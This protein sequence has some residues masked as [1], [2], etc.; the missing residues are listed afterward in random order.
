MCYQAK[1]GDKFVEGK[2]RPVYTSHKPEYVSQ[3]PQVLIN[4]GKKSFNYLE[5]YCGFDIETTNVV[6]SD[7]K[8]GY[9]YHGQMSFFTETE[10]ILYTVRTWEQFKYLIDKL[11]SHFH[12]SEKNRL[13]IW[14]ANM[15][16]E[17]QFM[18]KWFEW[19]QGQF[20]FFAKEKHHP[21]LATYKGVEF[22]EALSISGSSLAQLCKDFTY[23]QKLV[24]KYDYNK[25]RNNQYQLTKEELDYCMNDVIPLAEWSKFI[26]DKYI[27]VENKVPLTKTGLTRA[28]VKAAFDS[29]ENS[30]ELGSVINQAFPDEETYATMMKYL[31]RGGYVHANLPYVDVDC[32]DVDMYDITSS[33]PSRMLLGYFPLKFEFVKPDLKYL[34]THCCILECVFKGLQQKTT[35]SIESQHKLIDS[36]N[37][38]LDNGRVMSA[39]MVHVMLTEFDYKIYD[40]FYHWDS[41]EIKSM[42]ISKRIKLPDYVTKPLIDAYITKAKLKE[43]GKN[44]TTEY[45]LA[46]SDVNGQYGMMVTRLQLSDVKY[47]NDWT[48]IEA[49]KTFDD[50]RAKAILLPQWGIYVS[51]QARYEL[52]KIVHTITEKCGNIV[53]YN[54]TDSIKALHDDRIEQIIAEYNADI[55]Q[56]LKNRN[57]TNPL[58]SDLGMYDN[59][60]KAYKFKTLG[61][62]RYIMEIDKK[63]KREVKVKI[64]GL[65]AKGVQA[66]KEAGHDLFKEFNKEGMKIDETLANKNI[67]YYNP[68]ETS[69]IIDGVLMT[70]KSSV[71]IYPTTFKM[72]L[73]KDFY[74]MVIN[75]QLKGLNKL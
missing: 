22:R 68:N 62:K 42:M 52:L 24:D 16:F 54:D 50:E 66:F 59:E 8:A 37:V 44:D 3:I 55:A 72:S 34:D 58:L 63:G 21:L 51:C 7:H 73:N 56:Q 41:I 27:K 14:I 15:G 71:C 6:T 18:R 11:I 38:Q 45:T 2:V 29:K 60:G 40:M 10:G 32:D 4:R 53:I 65:P 31:Y 64:S 48:E 33:Y 19:D 28:K 12:I 39:D 70:E 57:L 47:T 69:D 23:T 43:E 5:A 13:I 30:F 1:I 26:F 17:F 35:H 9:M 74:A 36:T 25:P 49:A 20:S 67:A 46:K 61:A 75:E